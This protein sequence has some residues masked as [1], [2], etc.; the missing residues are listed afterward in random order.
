MDI[1]GKEENIVSTNISN[2]REEHKKLNSEKEV[3]KA[4]QKELASAMQQ[5]EAHKEVDVPRVRYALSLYYNMTKIRWD[6]NCPTV[7]GYVS[8]EK[9]LRKFNID[10][11]K[12]SEFDTINL[13]WD[14]IGELSADSS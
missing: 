10:Q 11:T 3:V 1:I 2:L 5:S 6:F 4:K 13:L 9:A 14:M 7:K 12:Q 8:S